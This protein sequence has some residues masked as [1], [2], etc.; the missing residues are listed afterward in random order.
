MVGRKNLGF[1]QHSWLEIKHVGDTAET[2][3]TRMYHLAWHGVTQHIARVGLQLEADETLETLHTKEGIPTIDFLTYPSA[4]DLLKQTYR[5]Y[6]E[7]RG[8]Q[9]VN[10]DYDYKRKPLDDGRTQPFAMQRSSHSFE[11]SWRVSGKGDG[12]PL[13]NVSLQQPAGCGFRRGR[14]GLICIGAT[15]IPL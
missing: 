4:G 7:I 14:L 3:K 12:E 10:T 15:S 5:D 8:E 11:Q 9:R 1:D 13:L 6:V 2:Y